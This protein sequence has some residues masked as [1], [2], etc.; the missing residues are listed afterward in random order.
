MIVRFLFLF[1]G[2]SHF[3]SHVAIIFSVDCKH[4]MEMV[5]EVAQ[6]QG[7]KQ[8]SED[9]TTA[10]ELVEKLSVAESETKENKAGEEVPVA[11]SEKSPEIAPVKTESEKKDEPS[12]AS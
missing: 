10:A 11:L 3:N 1:A 6:S 4:F 7:K 8:E 2:S 9:A 5:E 12:S